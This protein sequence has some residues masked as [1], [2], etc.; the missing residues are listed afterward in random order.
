MIISVDIDEVFEFLEDMITEAQANLMSYEE[1]D[2][3][4]NRFKMTDIRQLEPFDAFLYGLA[5]GKRD[6]VEALRLE[7]EERVDGFK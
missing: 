5:N 1:F 4:F 6:V 2:S 7:L 3:K